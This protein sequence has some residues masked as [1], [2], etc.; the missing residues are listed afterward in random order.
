MTETNLLFQLYNMTRRKVRGKCKLL[1]ALH[2]KHFHLHKQAELRRLI[3]VVHRH[4]NVLHVHESHFSSYALLIH[5]EAFPGKAANMSA[6]YF[7]SS[8]QL[9]GICII[10]D[11]DAEVGRLQKLLKKLSILQDF[12]ACK[13]KNK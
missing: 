2:L 10:H 9:H 11:S 4:F 7:E 5:R 3:A 13:V 8:T 1:S 6:I 12:T